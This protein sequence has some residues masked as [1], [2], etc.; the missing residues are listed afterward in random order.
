MNQTGGFRRIKQEMLLASTKLARGKTESAESYLKRVT[1]F[2]LQEKKIR[3]IENLE[4]CTN[5]K[6]RKTI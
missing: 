3:K 5:L 4:Q 6:V 1:H 2:H